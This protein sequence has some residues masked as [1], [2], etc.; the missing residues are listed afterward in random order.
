M[1]HTKKLEKTSP[2]DILAR[3]TFGFSAHVVVLSAGMDAHV[4][5]LKRALD[6]IHTVMA[7]FHNLLYPTYHYFSDQTLGDKYRKVI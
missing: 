2:N 6:V 7:C 5:V 3:L 1:F 4:E